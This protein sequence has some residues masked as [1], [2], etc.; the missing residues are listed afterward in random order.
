MACSYSVADFVSPR[1]IAG[2]CAQASAKV[3]QT[4][5]L[6]PVLEHIAETRP[7]SSDLSPEI[8]THRCESVIAIATRGIVTVLDRYRAL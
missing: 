2:R 7:S 3:A 5:V 1:P 6:D 4:F 8:Q